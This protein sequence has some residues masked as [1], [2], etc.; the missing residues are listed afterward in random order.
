MLETAS[1]YVGKVVD[2]KLEADDTI[3]NQIADTLSSV[4]R[5][6]PEAFDKMFSDSM[7]DLLMVSYLSNITKTQLTISF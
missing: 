4:P 1:E 3:G 7:Q 5:I 6:R 2:G